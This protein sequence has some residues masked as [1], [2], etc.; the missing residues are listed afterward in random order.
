[1]PTSCVGRSTFLRRGAHARRQPHRDRST[2]GRYRQT[3]PFVLRLT[4]ET[5]AFPTFRLGGNCPHPSAP[6]VP[7]HRHPAQGRMHDGRTPMAAVSLP[8]GAGSPR[9]GL[10]V[11]VDHSSDCETVTRSIEPKRGMLHQTAFHLGTQQPQRFKPPVPTAGGHGI[12]TCDTAGNR[13]WFGLDQ[14]AWLYWLHGWISSGRTH[15]TPPE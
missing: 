1:M 11:P 9:L 4:G 2:G 15:E 7:P 14:D 6:I 13:V 5:S 8:A 3:A 12:W 10:V